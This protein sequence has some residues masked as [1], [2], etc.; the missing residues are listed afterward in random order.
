LRCKGEG[1]KKVWTKEFALRLV[2]G[3]NHVVVVSGSNHMVFNMMIIEDLH[4]R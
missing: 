3:S 2:S 4:D 1:A